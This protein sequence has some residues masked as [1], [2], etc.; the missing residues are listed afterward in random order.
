MSDGQPYWWYCNAIII[1]LVCLCLPYIVPK[2]V[3][4][5]QERYHT[6]GVSC[7]SCTKTL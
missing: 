6:A 3:E 1:I 4:V 2:E 7:I 5:A